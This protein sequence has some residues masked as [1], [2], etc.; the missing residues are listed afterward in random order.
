MSSGGSDR[1]R[2]A[3]LAIERKIIEKKNYYRA[4]ERQTADPLLDI[5]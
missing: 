3:I 4:H 2:G 5:T 1:R